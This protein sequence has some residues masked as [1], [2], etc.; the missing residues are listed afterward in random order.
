MGKDLRRVLG[1]WDSVAIGIAAI[2]A[3]IFV[4]AVEL[5]LKLFRSGYI[6]VGFVGRGRLCYGTITRLGTLSIMV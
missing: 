3:G 4:C 2:G 6:G 1:F 5:G